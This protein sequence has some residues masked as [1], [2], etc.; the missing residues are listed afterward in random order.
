MFSRRE[1][2]NIRTEGVVSEERERGAGCVFFCV[3]RTEAVLH[4]N[5]PLVPRQ[6][7]GILI[8]LTGKPGLPTDS[9][10]ELISSGRSFFIQNR[11]GREGAERGHK[12]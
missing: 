10:S 4:T 8:F 2:V 11:V 7:Q 6:E 12:H 3:M 5:R 1:R 9:G